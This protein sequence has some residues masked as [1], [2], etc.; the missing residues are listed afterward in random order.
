M[1]SYTRMDFTI[2]FLFC[3]TMFLSL[4]DHVHAFQ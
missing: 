2:L 1:S 3:H 4:S